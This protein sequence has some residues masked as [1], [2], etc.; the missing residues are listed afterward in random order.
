MWVT[1]VLALGGGCYYIACGWFGRACGVIVGSV[2]RTSYPMTN[3]TSQTFVI[4][5]SRS[6]AAAGHCSP[7]SCSA[8]AAVVMRGG[9]H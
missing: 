5:A 8:R 6:G 3:K 7:E 2:R 4:H 9:A 1:V